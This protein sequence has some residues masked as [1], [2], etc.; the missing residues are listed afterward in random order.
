L[1]KDHKKL[2]FHQYSIFWENW[3]F[4]IANQVQMVV[5]R[6]ITPAAYTE[7]SACIIHINIFKFNVKRMVS[8]LVAGCLETPKVFFIMVFI[9]ILAAIILRM[10]RCGVINPCY[11][12]CSSFLS[13]LCHFWNRLYPYIPPPYL[14]SNLS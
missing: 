7:N 4:H 6:I 3:L 1:W 11:A 14:I 5:D 2:M 10:L 12:Y 8:Q 9:A 13:W